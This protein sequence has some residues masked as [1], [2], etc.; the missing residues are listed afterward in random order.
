LTQAAECFR[1]A[2]AIQS[3]NAEALR[4]LGDVLSRLGDHSAALTAYQR[5]AQ[6]R[7]S[8]AS[9]QT[10]LGDA[11]LASGDSAAAVRA[12]EQAITLEPGCAPAHLRLGN[13]A[14][15]RGDASAA[16]RHVT[17]AARSQPGDPA[18][19]LAAAARLEEVG[20]S[21]DALLVLQEAAQHQ[22]SSADV[23]DAQG[24][25]LH[26]LGRLPEALDCYERALTIDE[27]RPQTWVH[28]GLALESTGALGRAIA[29]FEEALK[30]KPSDPQSI[31]SI[32]S[33]ALRMCDWDLFERMMAA[34]REQPEGIDHLSAFLLNAVDFTPAEV[35]ASLRR[36]A[37]AAHWPDAVAPATGWP[38]GGHAP[39]RVAY[40]SPDFRA[41]PVAYAIAGVIEHHDHARIAPIA[42]S[43]KTPDGS[44]VAARLAGAFEDFIDVSTLSDR[45][46]VQLM[47]ERKV[48]IAIDLAGLTT[49]ARSSIFAMRSAPLQIS[50]LGYPGSTG[51]PCMDCIVA[52]S[53]VVPESDEEYFSERVVRMPYCYLPFDDSR[54]VASARDEARS[55]SGLPADAFVFCA[56]ANGYKISRSMFELWMAL[57][58]DVPHSVL[59]L[60]SMG[61]PTAANLRRA[62]AERGIDSSRLVFA[63]FIENMEAHLWRL[64]GADLFLDTTPYNGHTTAAEALWAGVPVLAC[65]GHSFAGR[66]GASL[67]SACGL[68]ELVCSD[69][70]HYRSLALDIARSPVLHE[71]LREKLRQS[72]TSAPAFDTRRFTREFEDLLLQAHQQNVR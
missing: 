69:L 4:N 20:A 59:W 30:I 1:Q 51:I 17:A 47:R 37:G 43:L 38:A 21:A 15:S 36:R 23:H 67:L 13:L 50:F 48:D 61:A 35:A 42:I 9:A 72:R 55:K 64:Q 22:A 65:A 68:A 62:A 58:R 26:R 66:V 10:E 32:A 60:R 19:M 63:G 3:G 29:A 39:L 45:A 31:A 5:T 57:L 40:V 49:G 56:F 33:C 41:H 44:A 25:L 54:L 16:I 46:I 6:L 71:S 7:P 70:A 12:F 52:D 11:L 34:L 28:S 18:I 27:K 24:T 2:S 53:T 14:A 8:D